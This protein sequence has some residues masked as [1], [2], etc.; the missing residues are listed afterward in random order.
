MDLKDILKKICEL[1]TKYSSHNTPEMQERGQLIRNNLTS[2]IRNRIPLLKPAFDSI[3]DDLAVEGSDGI[4]R[5]TEAPWVR[6]YSKE[7]S[8]NAREG[9]YLVIHFAADGSGV[10]ITVGCGSTIWRAGDLTP[11]SDEE[12]KA[13]TSW[14]RK[15]IQNRWKSLD[16]FIDEIHIGAKAP[17]PKTFEKATAFAKKISVDKIDNSTLEKLILNA[18]ERLGEIYIAQLEKR[19]I[20]PGDQ[21]AE[22][23]AFIANPLKVKSGK[24]GIG[25]S[26][27]ERRAIEI[28]A[29]HC[30]LKFLRKEGFICKDTSATES[31]DILA[32]KD[33]E[34]FKVEVKG[35]TSDIC[36]SVLMTK[37]EV[38]LHR[39]EKGSTALVIVSQVRLSRDGSKISTSGGSLEALI[40][41]DIDKWIS[42]P[43]AFHV[44]RS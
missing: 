37:N 22:E 29:M 17:L 35:T 6:L 8:P 5:K 31:F 14:A 43:I 20:S 44:S 40:G 33:K 42:E 34:S 36:N 27:A 30:A 15:I 10:F 21:D 12:L 32:T 24:Q 25:L 11:V 39:N 28:H 23:V 41:W 16:P 9:F 1:Q 18:A 19:D 26:F 2:E 3:F 38:N 13:R 4:G 7:M